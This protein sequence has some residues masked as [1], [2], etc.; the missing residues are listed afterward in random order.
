MST[1]IQQPQAATTAAMQLAD[2]LQ[3]VSLASAVWTAAVGY[4]D[5]APAVLRESFNTNV[6]QYA[7]HARLP[8]GGARN[9]SSVKP[10]LLRRNTRDFISA[11][12]TGSRVGFSSAALWAHQN[13]ELHASAL[14]FATGKGLAVRPA[15]VLAQG[16]GQRPPRGWP[17]TWT[18]DQIDA[19]SK[20]FAE[21]S[22]APLESARLM[23]FMVCVKPLASQTPVPDEKE[24]E[25]SS[26][27]LVSG[28]EDAPA[29]NPLTSALFTSFLRSVEELDDEAIEWAQLPSLYGALGV[30]AA[31]RQERRAQGIT[32]LSEALARLQS[33]EVQRGL[34]RIPK[35]QGHHA[36]ATG[37][38]APA[39]AL[40]AAEHIEALVSRAM[41]L[42]SLFAQSLQA[43]ATVDDIA[44]AHER[45]QR[46][47]D[48]T[49]KVTQAH[50]S[51]ATL[52]KP[53]SGLVGVPVPVATPPPGLRSEPPVVQDAVTSQLASAPLLQ[54]PQV[55]LAAAASAV[56]PHLVSEP[57]TPGPPT[58][59]PTQAPPLLAPTEPPKSAEVGA[60]TP[61]APVTSLEQEPASAG[62]S[63][64]SG[65]APFAL[66][67]AD[68]FLT[69]EDSSRAAPAIDAAPND[70]RTPAELA[71]PSLRRRVA[72]EALLHESSPATTAAF[73]YAL[74][75]DGD[76]AGAYWIARALEAGGAQA[77]V[78]TGVLGAL[79]VSFHLSEDSSLLAA[80]LHDLV[81]GLQG[82]SEALHLQELRLAAALPSVLR[83]PSCG[84][85]AWLV[86]PP[87]APYLADV[88][89][90]VRSFAAYGQAIP[91]SLREVLG[92]EDERA[93]R[94][95]ATS[96]EASRW[97]EMAP[98]KRT[99]QGPANTLW[100]EVVRTGDFAMLL[101]RAALDERAELKSTRE[102]LDRLREP[103]AIKHHVEQ[104]SRRYS[105]NGKTLDRVG[106][107]WLEGLLE[108]GLSRVE[109]WARVAELDDIM[110]GRGDWLLKQVHKLKEQLVDSIP[111]ALDGINQ[112]ATD[113]TAAASAAHAALRRSFYE[114]GEML[115]CAGLGTSS[116]TPPDIQLY[117]RLLSGGGNVHGLLARRLLT[118]PTLRLPAGGPRT[119]GPELSPLLRALPEQVIAP[120]SLASCLEEWMR[121]EDYR[122]T[123]PLLEAIEDAAEQDAQSERAAMA[124]DASRRRFR[125][126]VQQAREEVER[127]Y[128]DG[129]GI[130]RA[131]LVGRLE[132]LYHEGLREFQSAQR[133]LEEVRRALKVACDEKVAAQ[134]EAWATLRKVAVAE[135]PH[136]A[137]RQRSAVRIDELLEEHDYA[138]A[139]LLLAELKSALE[140][141]RPL[142]TALI[143][144]PQDRPQHFES[145]LKVLPMLEAELGSLNGRE[146]PKKAPELFAREL[147]HAQSRRDVRGL[148][149]AWK[150]LDTLRSRD[151]ALPSMAASI[152]ST[153]GFRASPD[154]TTKIPHVDERV[155]VLEFAVSSASK[156]PVPH[157]GSRVENRLRV[158]CT[159]ATVT[160]RPFDAVGVRPPPDGEGA[161]VLYGGRLGL[162]ERRHLSDACRTSGHAAIVVDEWLFLYLA[163]LPEDERLDALF[164]CALPFSNV[165]PYSERAS[166]SV[167]PE[168]FFGRDTLVQELASISGTCLVYGGRQL[169]KSALLEQVERRFKALGGAESSSGRVGRRTHNAIRL[170]IKNLG[171]PAS[172]KQPEALWAQLADELKRVGFLPKTQ[173]SK[174]DSLIGH[175]TDFLGGE[176]TSQLL[177]LLDEADNFL[178]S[179]ARSDFQQVKRLSDLMTRNP[180]RC[181]V[182]LAGLHNVQRFQGIPNQPLAHFGRALLVGPLEPRYADQ[183]VRRPLEALGFRFASEEKNSA[184]LR[185]LSYTNYHPGLIQLFCRE[186]VTTLH[187]RG[188][189]NLQPPY[190]VRLADVEEVYRK[191]DT[192][193]LIRERFE[194][195]LALDIRYQAIAWSV[196]VHNDGSAE[197]YARAFS[198]DDILSQVTTFWPQG[199]DGVDQEQMRALLDELDGLGVLARD[200]R[201]AYR[202]RSPNVVR[203][204]GHV[205]TIWE[206][207]GE[208][209]KKT[210]TGSFHVDY[211][212]VKLD[213]ERPPRFSP[214]TYAQG[215][216]LC[217][218]RSHASIVI[219]S[220]ATHVGDLPAALE[221]L[222]A[223]KESKGQGAA[224]RIPP[225]ALT[226][227]RLASWLR[228]E[229]AARGTEGGRIY[230]TELTAEQAASGELIDEAEQLC[231]GLKRA[232]GGWIRPLFVMRPAVAWKWMVEACLALP[233]R[234]AVRVVYLRRWTLPAVDRLFDELE[235]RAEER[236][237]RHVLDEV[238][239]GWPWLMHTY[240]ESAAR[241]LA[242]GGKHHDGRQAAEELKASLKPRG[243]L[244]EEFWSALEL[245][246]LP[247]VCDALSLIRDVQGTG[248]DT[249]LAAA[250]GDAPELVGH[251]DTLL[252][253]LL[254]LGC[255]ELKDRTLVVERRVAEALPT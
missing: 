99:G 240:A 50:Q 188:S 77:P 3:D 75:E 119:W 250:I 239:G 223:A 166:A 142:D 80:G 71:P 172:D 20:E 29:P 198:V 211:H 160:P 179:D 53:A 252:Q 5:Q 36:W 118:F 137:E 21:L 149:D 2:L 70:S 197:G 178:D 144:P 85:V 103:G 51:V 45:I 63:D 126:A 24:A 133:V 33:I 11:V 67:P 195:T 226:P 241:L 148:Y 8:M 207:L 128:V 238:T 4:R 138:N 109:D 16:S 181:K 185:I 91:N 132:G 245:E 48:L 168:M 87:G 182:V 229:S 145:F 6:L 175:I 68:E 204:L 203:L 108:E 42:D 59:Q 157:F 162:R 186:L 170:N 95:A 56:Q 38:F 89:D 76:V 254:A 34:Q 32:R 243:D 167:P 104:L 215:R 183:L 39:T 125:L 236:F 79:A 97:L 246:G 190:T 161:L 136:H 249:D 61:P 82:S 93:E 73:L 153:L 12:R 100:R 92:T 224:I 60:T 81:I 146:V 205:D 117:Q 55:P 66:I 46:I 72:A 228:S 244:G 18:A 139:D 163:G 47:L 111:I 206:R 209:E 115:R 52:L 37:V 120:P 248:F 107:D 156:S 192:R 28:R 22:G 147:T 221:R 62:A 216:Q 247:H 78:P 7:R 164:A 105:R 210:F 90:A 208:L 101:K 19:L 165:N 83:T 212:H 225:E 194:W 14:R 232:A 113:S 114:L 121:Q 127:V 84:L 237:R 35:L 65:S 10:A 214:L 122:F 30:L 129:V 234:R 88:V 150:R 230:W 176:R 255:L 25:Q 222:V 110:R 124:F 213:E 86:V 69:A 231:A 9:E 131:R 130:D 219:G 193:R 123:T 152:L 106:T 171:D 31:R 184:V 235:L 220:P 180:N 174:P 44:A 58:P 74:V 140:T 159:N 233:S 217:E 17:A 155:A 135:G 26:S 27:A 43:A 177:I 187:R 218:P 64:G 227:G 154:G 201:G 141:R 189:P 116:K 112:H 96:S 40:T 13:A 1:D 102:A 202:M 49:G 169:G 143:T 54:E 191:E 15:E 94:L 242:K 158:H 196:I 199:F 251:T 200:E 98:S 23:L 173:S 134:V 151:L 41:E 57:A 253:L